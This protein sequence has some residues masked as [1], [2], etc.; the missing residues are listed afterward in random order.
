M[1]D[2]LQ[3]TYFAAGCFWGVEK[4]FAE[5]SGVVETAVGYMGGDW[6]QPTYE[7]VCSGET[8]H[9]ETV[10]VRFDPERVTYAEL[11]VAFWRMHNPSCLNY[12][13]W[14]VGTQYRTALFVVDEEQR[15]QAEA[16]RAGEDASGC[17][18]APIV[19]EITAA[20]TFWRAEEYHQKYLFKSLK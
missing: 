8:G 17:H 2:R 15:R 18:G 7:Q 3:V 14:D 1:S 16:S 5:L 13:G 10:E 19:T 4:K 9:A 6:P 11:L 20:E 12:Q